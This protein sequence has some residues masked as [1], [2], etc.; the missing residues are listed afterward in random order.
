MRGEGRELEWRDSNIVEML[1]RC[2][3]VVLAV[4]V[5]GMAMGML[6]ACQTQEGVFSDSYRE[7]EQKGRFW[8]GESAVETT[9][10]RKQSMNLPFGL[11]SG[12]ADQ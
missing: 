12:A 7:T 4:A 3:L 6:S 9:Q 1:M 8:D 5:G 2:G 10:S 11:P